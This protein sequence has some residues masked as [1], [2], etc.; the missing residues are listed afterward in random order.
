[1]L[2]FVTPWLCHGKGKSQ[3]AAAAESHFPLMLPLLLPLGTGYRS[4]LEE[5]MRSR[6]YREHHKHFETIYYV[7]A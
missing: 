2:A 6:A 5:L 7:K 3:Q 1:M 4:A